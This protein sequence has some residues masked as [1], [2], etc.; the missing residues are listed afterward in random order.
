MYD[1]YATRIMSYAPEISGFYPLRPV[2]VWIIDTHFN[3]ANSTMMN[4]AVLLKISS[5]IDM[6]R[7][8]R[9]AEEFFNAHD[10][11]RVRFVFHEQTSD[12]CQRFDGEIAPV[13]VEKISDEEFE[14][15]KKFL[16]KPYKLIDNPLYRFRL[17][18]TPTAKYVYLDFYHAIMDG[19]SVAIL[20]HREMYLRYKGKKNSHQPLKYADYVLNELKV[21][22]EELETGNEYWRN[23]LADFDAKKH[24]P[25]TDIKSE[26]K[27]K[28]NQVS[29]PIKNITAK[30]FSDSTGK[31]NP[32]IFFFAAAM[33]TITKFTGA[34]NS[35]MSYVHNGRTTP[36]EMRLTGIMIDQ[37]P[38]RWDFS[39]NERVKNFLDGLEEK[40]S[41]GLQHRRSLGTV[42]REGLEDECATFI[43]QKNFYTSFDFG[44]AQLEAVDIPENEFS[45]AENTLDIEVN[46]ETDGSFYVRLDYDASRYS[47]GK[48]KKFAETFDEIILQ[49]QDEE[50]LVSDI[51]KNFLSPSNE[52]I[53]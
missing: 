49:M 1:D 17:F 36:Q 11:F 25:P 28:S 18:E 31:D 2:Q 32:E 16:M 14:E 47:E 35:I 12:L 43:F 48:M 45:A 27:W 50:R 41:E 44:D 38:V 23:I 4:I 30:Y 37:I 51:L 40:F 8:A 34:K 3:K 26:I 19:M 52:S 7:L 9:A 6:T 22:P 29:S 15:Q 46:Q 20:F 39:P 42:Y 5:E 33:L 24:L 10:I 21:S 53:R 13:T